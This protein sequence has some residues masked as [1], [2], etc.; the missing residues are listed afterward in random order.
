[1]AP[2]QPWSSSS[3]ESLPE[4][5]DLKLLFVLS[6]SEASLMLSLVDSWSVTVVSLFLNQGC[7]ALCYFCTFFKH[8]FPSLHLSMKA[9]EY[10]WEQ[11]LLQLWYWTLLVQDVSDGLL[12]NSQV[13]SLIHDAGVSWIRVR[14]FKSSKN[15]CSCLSSLANQRLTL[16]IKDSCDQPVRTAF[17]P[18]RYSISYVWNQLWLLLDILGEFLLQ[19][20][21]SD[22]FYH[23]PKQRQL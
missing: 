2:N 7:A 12:D 10:S 14:T 5:W 4:L 18:R 1:M 15:F 22:W 23:C 21:I 9:L 19:T 11:Q 3:L 16:W 20:L 17:A 8:I 6:P 13:R